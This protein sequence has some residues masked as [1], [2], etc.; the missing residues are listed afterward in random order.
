MTGAA[1]AIS[2]Q[3]AAELAANARPDP[4]S[5]PV[6]YSHMRSMARSPA[7]ALHAMQHD[8]EAT[9]SMRIG[10]GAHSLLLGGPPVLC[11]PTKQRRGKDFDAWFATQPSDAIVLSKKEHARAIAIHAAVSSNTLARQVLTVPGTL[12]EDTIIWEQ[13]GRA[14]R[15]TPDARTRDHVVE[16]KT[17]RDASPDRFRWDV[18]R[19]GY[20][21][22]LA[23]QAEA[24]RFIN[25]VAP[26]RCYI[27]A[28]ENNPPHLC[29]VHL[30]TDGTI[31]RATKRNA[32]WLSQ[33]LE[34]EQTGKWPGYSDQILDLDVPDQNMELVFDES[35]DEEVDD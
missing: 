27:I 35:D 23:D 9:L 28:V 19:M 4:R 11:C 21:G 16:L 18:A 15:S 2:E 29:T 32:Q 14:R 3:L 33:L 5:L 34:C 20:D 26:R 8:Y 6:R 7:H 12:F 10:K 22:Q 24:M 30:L 1:L 31:E 25:G 17:C 13:S